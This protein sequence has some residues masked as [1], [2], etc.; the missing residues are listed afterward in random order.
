MG[1]KVKVILNSFALYA[2][3]FEEDNN[4]LYTYIGQIFELLIHE[5][6]KR[7]RVI[8]SV[9]DFSSFKLKKINMI[10]DVK[11]FTLLYTL[12]LFCSIIKTVE[13]GYCLIRLSNN[14][15]GMLK[16]PSFFHSA[17]GLSSQHRTDT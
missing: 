11:A 8:S 4:L 1:M 13:L 10:H 14:F 7:K 15:K 2:Y 5:T 16:C 3:K 12:L 6:I 9:F 17:F